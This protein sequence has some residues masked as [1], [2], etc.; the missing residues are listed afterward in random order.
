MLFT[1][2]VAS[3]AFAGAACVG[4][5]QAQGLNGGIVPAEFPPPGYQGRQYVDSTG[6]VF[7]R[8]GIDGAVT[9]VPRVDRQRRQMCGQ[10][11]TLVAGT[12]SAPAAT[13]NTVSARPVTATPAA[14]PARPA[15]AQP[16]SVAAVPGAVVVHPQAAMASGFGPHTRVVPKHVY[17]QNLATQSVTVP[18]GYETVWEDD[19]LNPRRAEQS[20]AGIAASRQIWRETVPQTLA[21]QKLPAG[22]ERSRVSLSVAGGREDDRVRLVHRANKAPVSHVTVS[23]RSVPKD[24]AMRYV[25]V[26]RMPDVASAKQAAAQLRRS[27]LPTRLG[28]ERGQEQGPVLLLAGP[29]AEGAAL[30]AGLSR[31]RAAGFPSARIR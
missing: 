7:I 26:T 13:V 28:R 8:A 21:R 14:R 18:P 9:W 24:A 27:G 22:V 19:R 29:Y 31:V 15:T 3:A 25:E 16:R 20:L 2:L 12:T 4:V 5:L 10:P 30:Q 1:R 17:L 11:P 23:T 6:C